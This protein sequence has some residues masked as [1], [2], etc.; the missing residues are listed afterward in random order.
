MSSLTHRRSSLHSEK[1]KRTFGRAEPRPFGRIG[2]AA[3]SDPFGRGPTLAQGCQGPRLAADKGAVRVID[4]LKQL[5]DD[6]SSDALDTKALVGRRPWRRLRVG[7]YR[8][9]FRLAE[10]GRVLL[11]ARVVDRKELDR[12]LGS[13]PD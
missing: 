6:P 11:V 4:A 3:V 7:E 13:L 2:V 8:V 1:R 10:K 12:A 5:G 9:L